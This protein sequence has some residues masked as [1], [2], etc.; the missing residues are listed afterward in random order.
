[1]NSPRLQFRPGLKMTLFVV[2]LWPLLLGLGTWQLQRAHLKSELQQR[3]FATQGTL[4]VTAEEYVAEHHGAGFEPGFVRVRLDGHY[5]GTRQFLVDNR[6]HRGVAGY[7]VIT[8]LMTASGRFYINRGWVAG[9][10]TRAELPLPAVP[11][12]AVT[13]TVQVW[14][15]TGSLPVFGTDDWDDAW[16]KRI[17]QLDFD[18]INAVLGGGHAVEMRLEAGQPGA[19]TITRSVIDF[20][21]ARHIGYAVQWFGLAVVL[22]V[23]FFWFGLTREPIR[24]LEDAHSDVRSARRA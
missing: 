4:P 21:A 1:M 17:Q 5:E 12:E 7:H 8:P 11:A 20:G 13:I 9:G 24:T 15:D 16:P 22:A 6:T 10:A 18:R 19:L 2:V 23:G 14:P 3:W